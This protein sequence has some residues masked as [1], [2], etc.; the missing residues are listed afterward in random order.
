[1]SRGKRAWLQG[2]GLKIAAVTAPTRWTSRLRAAVV[3]VLSGG[4]LALTAG[5]AQAFTLVSGKPSVSSSPTSGLP[6][7]S[8]T[9]RAKY[10]WSGGTCPGTIPMTFKFYWYKVVSNKKLLWTKTVS[11]CSA[12]VVDTLSSP[13]LVPPAPLNYPSSFVIQ[14]GVYQSSGAHFPN[15][16]TATTLYRVTPPT[17]SPSPRASP[18]TACG[19][20]GA[21]A[22]PSA[23]PST[24]PCAATQSAILPPRPGG[25]DTAV[26]LALALFSALPIGGVAMVMS[27]GLWSRRKEWRRLAALL[28]LSIVMLAAS[29]CTA[30]GNQVANVSPEQSEAAQSPSPSPTP[31]C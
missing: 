15:P 3:A 25:S 31:T 18:T 2:G 4:L 30:I 1:M 19:Q 16:Y 6:T 12:G 8:F 21:A 10:A 7:A 9:V 28:G 22:C 17:P 26:V 14:V 13:A 20:P 27:P 29:G 5:S 23:S 11:A 24:S